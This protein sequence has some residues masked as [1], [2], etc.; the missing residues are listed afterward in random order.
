MSLVFACPVFGQSIQTEP[1]AKQ[2]QGEEPN[3]QEENQSGQR[4]EADDSDFLPITIYGPQQKLEI[5]PADPPIALAAQWRSGFVGS[6]DRRISPSAINGW[7]Q[8]YSR[9]GRI[10]WTIPCRGISSFGSEAIVADAKRQRIYIG[11]ASDSDKKINSQISALDFNGNRLWTVELASKSG[12]YVGTIRSLMVDPKT[13]NLWVSRD[14]SCDTNVFDLEGRMIKS[15][16]YG[17]SVM[18]YDHKT[19]LFW[20]F[21]DSLFRFSRDFKMLSKSERVRGGF[22][23]PRSILIDEDGRVWTSE[24]FLQAPA[25]LGQY[26]SEGKLLRKFECPQYVSRIESWAN[27]K[28]ILY[29][30]SSSH[31]GH[32][33]FDKKT[34]EFRRQLAELNLVTKSESAIWFHSEKGLSATDLESKEIFSQKVLTVGEWEKEREMRSE[35]LELL[36][37]E[38]PETDPAL[39]RARKVVADWSK[40]IEGYGEAEKK[41]K[42]IYRGFGLHIIRN[43]NLQVDE[44]EN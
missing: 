14:V 36:S 38:L 32:M 2:Q 23:H 29:T 9:S 22:G 1:L 3:R 16:P 4:A 18:A 27:G 28:M 17:S 42:K 30:A 33:I 34:G 39:R 11:E 5:D 19:D 20:M 43:Q 35:Q 13:G 12:Q 25:M 44:Q 40:S 7:L 8:M 24:D 26:S 21:G 15:I 6:E 37:K 10:Q 41:S 31:K